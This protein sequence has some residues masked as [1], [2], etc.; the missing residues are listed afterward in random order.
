MKETK[1]RFE[2]LDALRGIAALIVVLFH[3][4][5]QYRNFYGHAF[6]EQLDFKYGHYGVPLFFIIS[7]FVIFMTVNKVKSTP[8]FIYKRFIRLY[9][10]FWICMIITFLGVNYWGLLPKFFTTWKDALFNLIMFYRLIP[11]IKD[12]DGAYWSLLPELKFYFLIV[13]LLFFKQIKNIKWIGLLWFA[14]IIIENYL[15]HIRFLGMFIELQLG[16]FFIAGIFFYKIGV[17]KENNFWN[18]LLIVATLI[19]NCL[20][21]NK[22]QHEGAFVF[23]PLVY[24]VFYLFTFGYL[25]WLKSKVLL[26]LGTISY[27][28][29]LIHQNLGY[30]I[31][32]QFELWGFTGFYVVLITIV[33]FIGVA[34]LITFYLEQPLLKLLRNKPELKLKK[35]L[36]PNE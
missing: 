7:G 18:H 14:L 25:N 22:W 31:I 24:L 8:E 12:V 23:I 3:Y 26:F 15:Y 17:E 34:T 11:G 5:A 19:F 29:Y 30:T 1:N 28:L 36:I 20:L 27:P 10:T 32:R 16:G 2:P 21:Y 35:E 33:F 4:T 13:L 6:S 9:P